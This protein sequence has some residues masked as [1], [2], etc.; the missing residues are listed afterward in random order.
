MLPERVPASAD[1][2]AG[3]YRSVLSGQ[4]VLILL[5]N[6]RDERQVRPLLPASPAS[7]VLVTSRSQLGG[8]SADGARLL[9]LDVFTRAEAVHLL[10]A[11]LGRDRAAAEP[12]AVDQ[13]AAL[14]AC[15]PLAL[16][17]AA[18]RAAGRPRLPLAALA[19]ELADSAGRLEALDGDDPATSVRAVF[20][21]SA[22]QLDDE[23]AR[24]F[25][26]LGLHPGPDIS[27]PAAASLAGRARP[28][29]RRL[30][31]ELVRAHL[32]A[33]PVPGRY[34]FH[35]L[36]RSYAAEKARHRRERAPRG[37]RRPAGSSITTCALP[38]APPSC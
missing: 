9:P 28:Q 32:I 10:T 12:G 18:A 14:C 1:A 7:M 19:A 34:T 11:R 25:R 2:Q 35:D 38:R 16:A 3:L 13:V 22:R 23:S 17:V 20:S 27:V 31:R 4:R 36:L 15:L 24:M 33:E 6:A 30:L 26:L 29:A 37:A 8:L 21:W 5:D